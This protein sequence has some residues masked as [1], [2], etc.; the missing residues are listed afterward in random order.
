MPGARCLIYNQVTQLP[1]SVESV[2]FLHQAQRKVQGLEILSHW[3]DI[4][5]TLE[6]FVIQFILFQNLV[7]LSLRPHMC[8]LVP[9]PECAA[10]PRA[11]PGHVFGAAGLLRRENVCE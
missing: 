7:H 10:A 11:R 1:S 8:R 4:G 2:P 6:A 3:P 5:S 9:V